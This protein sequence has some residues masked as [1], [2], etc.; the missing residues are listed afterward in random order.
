MKSIQCYSGK[1]YR[2]SKF[3]TC[4]D[5]GLTHRIQ[6]KVIIKKNGRAWVYHRIWREDKMTEK[7]R[8]KPQIC[9]KINKKLLK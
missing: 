4:C 6:H 3:E 7:N 2:S 5:C 1:W 8:K 9:I